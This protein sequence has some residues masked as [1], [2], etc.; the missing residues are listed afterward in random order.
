MG[1]S[2]EKF[3]EELAK[4]RAK[5]QISEDCITRWDMCFDIKKAMERIKQIG[6]MYTE[7]FVIDKDNEFVYFN[8]LKWIHGD[9]TM[10]AID[11]MTKELVKGK[12]KAGLYIAGPAGTGKTLCLNIIRDYAQI[13]GAKVM[14]K[15]FDEK[16]SLVWRNYNAS[17]I[18]QEYI[19][20]GDVSE[21]EKN[22]VLCIQDFGC[23]PESVVYM[24]NKVNVL[25]NLI[26][27]RGD[28]CNRFTLITSNLPI[29][30]EYTKQRYEE[31]VISRL[32]QMCNYFEMKGQDRRR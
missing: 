2:N 4:V 17:D 10:Q 22:R 19:K 24:G 20:N 15:P 30:H 21:I 23:E 14:I 18:S 12:L 9:R 26:E 27:R 5:S 31:R 28:I 11:P 29:C 32:R 16:T 13:I 6:K 1:I 3:A 8:L 25:K 7:D